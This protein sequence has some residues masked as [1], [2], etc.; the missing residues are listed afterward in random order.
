MRVIRGY[1]KGRNLEG[2]NTLGTRPTMDRV[3]ESL[4]AMIQDNITSSVILDL[5]CG[6]GSLGIE[7]ISMGARKC[8]FV[9]NNREIIKYLTKSIVNLGIEDKTKIIVKDYRDALCYFK[10]HDITF[11]II[12][13][14]APYKMNIMEKII[15]IVSTKDIL[16]SGGLL[17]LEYSVDVLKD[18]YGDFILLKKKKYGNKFVNIYRKAID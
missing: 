1:L 7:A 4:F 2:Y 18:N 10:E 9:D 6:T 11:D 8:Y 14:D 15:E 13:V 3:K 17:I 12:L 5:F 16:N